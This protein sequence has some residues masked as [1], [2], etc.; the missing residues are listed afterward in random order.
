MAVNNITFKNYLFFF[1]EVSTLALLID[2][3]IAGGKEFLVSTF[4]KDSSSLLNRIL[5]SNSGVLV[6]RRKRNLVYARKIEFA[7]DDLTVKG[8]S[9]ILKEFKKSYIG[10]VADWLIARGVVDFHSGICVEE[11]AIFK[12]IK[13]VFWQVDIIDR[14]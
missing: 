9:R 11:D 12:Q 13:N 5:N 4:D 6:L 3:G 2:N 1:T 14:V 8:N 7:L 10:I